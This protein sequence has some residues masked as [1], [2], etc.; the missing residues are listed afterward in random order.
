MGNTGSVFL[1]G[2]RDDLWQHYTY[3]HHIIAAAYGQ[4]K[5]THAN[6]R[7]IL[8]LGIVGQV[9]WGLMQPRTAQGGRKTSMVGRRSKDAYHTILARKSD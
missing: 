3:Y 2:G 9:L 5:H 6:L 4:N 8:G 7:R 1:A